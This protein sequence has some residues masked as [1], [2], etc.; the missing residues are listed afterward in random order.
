MNFNLYQR[1]FENDFSKSA[2]DKCLYRFRNDH[3]F[4]KNVSFFKKTSRRSKF[5]LLID[6]F[7]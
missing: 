3:I 5:I 2:N 6:K 4:K 7:I 1:F